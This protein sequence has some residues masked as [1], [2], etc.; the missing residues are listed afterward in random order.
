MSRIDFLRVFPR[1]TQLL[2]TFWNIPGGIP[3]QLP[4]KRQEKLGESMKS[5]EKSRTSR[6]LV[7]KAHSVRCIF[8]EGS[9]VVLINSFSRFRTIFVH[10]A[11]ISYTFR[12]L[13]VYISHMLYT[14]RTHFVNFHSISLKPT[15]FWKGERKGIPRRLL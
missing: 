9:I 5:Y 10:F 7:F 11:H 3:A 1:P 14:F 2:K 8:M 13:F 4:T 12:T 15:L 6:S